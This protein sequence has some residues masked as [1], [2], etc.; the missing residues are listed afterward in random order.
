MFYAT[1]KQMKAAEAYSDSHGVSYKTL[2]ENAGAALTETICRLSLKHDLSDGILILCGKGNNGG[3][4]FTAAR[5]LAEAGFKVCAVLTSGDPATE[6]AAYEY[7]ELSAYDVEVMALNDNIDA[8]F[9]LFSSCALIVDAVY[10]TGFHGELPPELKACFSF[11]SRCGKIIVA[12]DVPSGGNCLTGEAAEGTLKCNYTVT[13]GC[14]K[15]G[16]LS[17]PLKSL[18]GEIITADIGFT[19]DCF[20]SES[21][22]GEGLEAEYVRSLF[23]KRPEN[24]YKNQ[25]GRLLCVAGSRRMSGAAAMALKAALRSGAGLVTL[26]STGEVTNR[27]AASCFEAM[28]LPLEGDESGAIAAENAD[29][30]LEEA[31][32][33]TAV[34]IG[35]GLSVTEGTKAVVKAVVTG[36]ECPIILDADGINCI[37]DC[38]DII[39]NTKNKLIVTPHLGELKRLYAAAFGGEADRLT[40]ALALAREYDIIV[41]AKGVP[42]FIAGDGKLYVCKAGNP[43]LS[44]GGSGDVLTGIISAFAAQ[45]LAPSDAAAAGVYVHGRAADLAA[46]KLSVMGMLPT[47]VIEE[48]P[49]VFKEWNR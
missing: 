33:C 44:R 27:I 15:T 31:K 49:F 24:S 36:A 4:G 43:G 12:A 13:F 19:E 41:A 1:P 22:V 10:G 17:E 16:M 11:A 34:A 32:K 38:I 21:Y 30:I 48:L 2:M 3:D 28:T 45:G 7:C 40:M 39:R 8:V 25:F 20:R 26:A 35:C 47:D 37:T 5:Y 42:N 6:L 29:I 46:E 9:G 18:C 23:P 14:V